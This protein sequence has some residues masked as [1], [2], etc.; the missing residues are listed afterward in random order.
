MFFVLGIVGKGVGDGAL[1]CLFLEAS[2]FKSFCF[3]RRLLRLFSKVSVFGGVYV[4]V[5]FAF[6]KKGYVLYLLPSNPQ[7][8]RYVRFL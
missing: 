5:L 1:F 4:F 7:L 6:F 2:I 8:V 3:W